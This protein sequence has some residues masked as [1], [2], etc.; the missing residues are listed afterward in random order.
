MRKNETEHK[1]ER[2]RER[3][4]ERERGRESKSDERFIKKAKHQSRLHI[5]TRH[6]GTSHS[7][8]QSHLKSVSDS[9]H[10]RLHRRP[11]VRT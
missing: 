1:R 10:P 7:S 5:A 6:T 2:V 4:R 11:F 8:G 9:Y 3:E